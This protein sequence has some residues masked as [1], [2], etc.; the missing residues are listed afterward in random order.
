L[1]LLLPTSPRAL[2]FEQQRYARFG[3]RGQNSKARGTAVSPVRSARAE[4][5]GGAVVSP[6]DYGSFDLAPPYDEA[7][8][9]RMRSCTVRTLVV[10]GE[11]DGVIPVENGRTYRCFVSNC[12]FQIVHDAAHDIQGDRPEAFAD[13][14]GDF[15]RRGMAFLVPNKDT[16]INP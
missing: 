9:E 3:T 2:H 6:D 11:F 4:Q 13:L 1:H 16:L 15:L 10:L 12:S 8:V 14:V 5:G 7:L